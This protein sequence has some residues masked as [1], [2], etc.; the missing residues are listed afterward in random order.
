LWPWLTA[1]LTA[2]GLLIGGIVGYNWAG[3]TT[4]RGLSRARLQGL[5][6]PIAATTC[7][8]NSVIFRHRHR[9]QPGLSGRGGGASR[10]A[11]CRLD[12]RLASGTPLDPHLESIA[13]SLQ[14]LLEW[15]TI[16]CHCADRAH[17]DPGAPE[18]ATMAGV[19]FWRG[20]ADLGSRVA[21]AL[22][23]FP[24]GR[25]ARYR[26]SGRLQNAHRSQQSRLAGNE[27]EAPD[28]TAAEVKVPV[29]RLIAVR[30]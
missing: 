10:M 9:S 26:S 2:L 22:F 28:E 17:S 23:P 20:T 7:A 27:V 5:A 12:I 14:E 30:R 29:N 13:I 1:A 6:R 21:P 3:V 8:S 19:V 4:R 16:A 11:A 15:P 25:G 24:T 18:R